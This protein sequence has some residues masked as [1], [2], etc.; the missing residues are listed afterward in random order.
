MALERFI[1]A[2]N[3]DFTRALQEVKNGHKTTHWIWYTFPQLKGLGRSYNAQY[4]G[5]EG[6]SE[7]RAYLKEPLLKQRLIE[8]A[9]AFYNVE[10]RSAAEVF[11]ILDAK[12]VQS[13]M[14]L[15]HKADPEIQIFKQV[16]DKYYNGELDWK[17]LEGCSLKIA[18]FCGS[19]HGKD[20]AFTKAA[21]AL[22][23]WIGDHHH[24][25]VYG[26]GHA[27]NMGDVSLSALDHHGQC[28]SV[29]PLFLKREEDPRIKHHIDV[30]T[31]S[32]RKDKMI[33][34]ADAFVALPGG[35]GTL[36]EISDVISLVRLRR[37]NA[38][39][40]FYNVNGFYDPLMRF[41]DEMVE[42]GYFTSLH[43]SEVHFVDSLEELTK[44]IDS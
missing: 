30:E 8:I 43:R 39:Y 15:F 3:K 5:I 35:P 25:L 10:G 37:L 11:G 29:S 7:A 28:I 23:A 21:K 33:E 34:L 24:T 6:L 41:Y 2:Q 12:K 16:L 32:E 4:Y 36:E 13:C 14:T 31:L 42:Q 20:P 40:C 38:P 27:G 44:I 19:T 17:T 9:T 22:G 18:V 26:G 1:E